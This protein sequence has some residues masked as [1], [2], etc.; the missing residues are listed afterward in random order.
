[1]SN[2]PRRVPRSKPE[3][4]F[5]IREVKID[6]FTTRRVRIELHAGVCEICAFDVAAANK[7]DPNSDADVLKDLVQRHKKVEHTPAT[8]RI[9]NEANIPKQWTGREDWLDGKSD[10]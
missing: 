1:M 2:N 5:I 8:S 6:K 10:A 7:L 3:K 9:V 4:R